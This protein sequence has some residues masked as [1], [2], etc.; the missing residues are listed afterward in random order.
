MVSGKHFDRKARSVANLGRTE[1]TRRIIGFRGRFGLD[2]TKNILI[3]CQ[4]T[5]SAIYSWRP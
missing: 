2:F 1:L 3:T 5:G 4:W